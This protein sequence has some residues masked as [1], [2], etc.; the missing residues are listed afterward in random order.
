MVSGVARQKNGCN[1]D[2]QVNN[3]TLH[4][5]KEMMVKVRDMDC[6]VDDQVIHLACLGGVIGK[7]P[8]NGGIGLRACPQALI[9]STLVP[10]RGTMFCMFCINYAIYGHY[11]AHG[12][13][14]QNR[15]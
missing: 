13:H 2:S 9:V 8:T 12:G 15:T 10:T 4:W 6:L 3:S 11:K 14:K 5:A 1:V 7:C